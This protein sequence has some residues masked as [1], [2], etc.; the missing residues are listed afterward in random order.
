MNDNLQDFIA[1]ALIVAQMKR[2]IQ[3]AE[4]RLDSLGEALFKADGHVARQ[5]MLGASREMLNSIRRSQ[6]RR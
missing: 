5:N 3:D 4:M 6:R 1:Q 2:D